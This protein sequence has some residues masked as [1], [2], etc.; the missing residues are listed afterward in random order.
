[1]TGPKMVA[2]RA[3]QAQAHS[4]GADDARH[5]P[6][7]LAALVAHLRAA[8]D[9]VQRQLPGMEGGEQEPAEIA[10]EDHGGDADIEERQR[11]LAR[12]K[13][14]EL[15]RHALRPVQEEYAETHPRPGEGPPREGDEAQD[16][17]SPRDA[18]AVLV[19][20]LETE[21]LLSRRLS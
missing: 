15:E 13:L 5:G 10:D 21:E 3:S 7:S 6:L 2:P 20:D 17:G 18:S 4:R 14:S 9:V 11:E 16:R 1:M 12:R 19:R 8:E